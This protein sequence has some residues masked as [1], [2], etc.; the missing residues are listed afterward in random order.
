MLLPVS[1]SLS[2]IINALTKGAKAG[3]GRNFSICI[4]V[5]YQK[6]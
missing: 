5:S 1:R 2:M 6:A 3:E 4:V